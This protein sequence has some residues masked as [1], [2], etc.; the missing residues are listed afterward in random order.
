M[1]WIPFWSSL[2][3][4]HLFLKFTLGGDTLKFDYTNTNGVLIAR[5]KVKFEKGSKEYKQVQRDLRKHLVRTAL[6]RFQDGTFLAVKD[7]SIDFEEI[8]EDNPRAGGAKPSRRSQSI[9]S[10]QARL[11]P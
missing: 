8:M 11:N 1:R 7:D 10:E 3:Y 9:K 6:I 2:S 5:S 4:I